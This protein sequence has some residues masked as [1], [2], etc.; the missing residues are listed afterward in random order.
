MKR[1]LFILLALVI[2]LAG[3]AGA[4]LTDANIKRFT[5]SWLSEIMASNCCRLTDW[6]EMRRVSS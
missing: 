3:A 4:L 6:V 2:V 5:E 1:F